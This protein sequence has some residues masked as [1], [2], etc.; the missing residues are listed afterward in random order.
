M[1]VV[2]IDGLL[3][4]GSTRE[5]VVADVVNVPVAAVILPD[6][7]RFVTL[8]VVGKPVVNVP[9][10]STKIGCMD[11]GKLAGNVKV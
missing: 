11:V 6:A 3:E 9:V 1:K 4:F 7:V 2:V 8:T 10:A 5:F